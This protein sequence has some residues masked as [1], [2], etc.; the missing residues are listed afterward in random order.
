MCCAI[1]AAHKVDE[2]KD[3]RD[4]A[5][6][7]E[8]C[9]RQAHNVEAERQAAEIRMRAERKVGQ[10]HAALPKAKGVASETSLAGRAVMERPKPPRILL[11][12]PWIRLAYDDASRSR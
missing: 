9:A 6:A 10:L 2:V 5:I 7:L 3:I 1:A 11:A 12:R 8:T 4:K